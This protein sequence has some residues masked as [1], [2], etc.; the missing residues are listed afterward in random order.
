MYFVILHSKI[1]ELFLF[2]L[3]GFCETAKKKN[4]LHCI[5]L[6]WSKNQV[7]PRKMHSF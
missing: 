7:L 3:C 2:Y 4:S 1:T 6:V 5:N